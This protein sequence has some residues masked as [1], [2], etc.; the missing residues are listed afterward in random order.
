MPG[1]GLTPIPSPD[2]KAVLASLPLDNTALESL[3]SNGEEALPGI[4][5]FI[6]EDAEGIAGFGNVRAI[7]PVAVQSGAIVGAGHET[8]AA[9]GATCPGLPVLFR[10]R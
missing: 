10:G 3:L 1:I 4:V 6:R 7:V 5:E 2:G 8:L 9:R